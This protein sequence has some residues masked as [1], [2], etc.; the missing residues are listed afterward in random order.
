MTSTTA[1]YSCREGVVPVEGDGDC[2]SV[3][4]KRQQVA[5]DLSSCPPIFCKGQAH[6]KISKCTGTVLPST[7]QA[8]PPGT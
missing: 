3:R 5:H 8:V 2:S 7:R 6:P 4:L 1:R